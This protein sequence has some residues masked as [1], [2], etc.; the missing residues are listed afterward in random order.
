MIADVHTHR[1]PSLDR[2]TSLLQHNAQGRGVG[3]VDLVIRYA[4]SIFKQNLAYR[5]GFGGSVNGP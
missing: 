5:R 1:L 2:S 3:A 4:F